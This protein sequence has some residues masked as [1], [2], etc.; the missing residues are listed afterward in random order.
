MK[1]TKEQL[2]FLDMFALVS[3]T[4]NIV[5]DK[6]QIQC[7]A[8]K[9]RVLFSINSEVTSLFYKFDMDVEKDSCFF[10]PINQVY[11]IV[12][13]V[14]DD[15]SIDI[16]DNV[17]SFGKDSSYTFTQDP[18]IIPT[19]DFDYMHKNLK[20]A[21]SEFD[22]VDLGKTTLL[23]NFIGSPD[24]K[25]DAILLTNSYFVASNKT[26]I[27]GAIETSNPKDLFFYIP[28]MILNLVGQK[29]KDTCKIIKTEGVIYTKIDDVEIFIVPCEYTLPDI[30]GDIKSKLKHSTFVMFDKKVFMESLKRISVT[31]TNNLYNRI[32]LTF[33]KDS[34]TVENKDTGYACEKV[35]CNNVDKELCDHTIAVSSRYMELILNSFEGTTITMGVTNT[36][37]GNTAITVRF[38]DEKTNRFFNHILYEKMVS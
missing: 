7:D 37:D 27:I 16:T 33:G 35:I 8:E 34:I 25:F 21:D 1:F 11:Q 9:K 26:D 38:E 24:T 23:K 15:V 14:P 13:L 6:L 17:I 29:K 30:F 31:T 22:I 10:F 4:K 12:Q 20:K 5:N 28:K 36:S 19:I 2:S 3:D 32:H 18:N